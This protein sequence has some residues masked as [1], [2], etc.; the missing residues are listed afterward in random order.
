MLQQGRPRVM[1]FFRQIALQKSKVWTAFPIGHIIKAGAT[2]A[3]LGHQ[4]KR[5]FN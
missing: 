2:Q 4:N 5:A 1:P 3:T